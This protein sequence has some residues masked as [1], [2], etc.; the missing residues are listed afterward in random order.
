MNAL[1]FNIMQLAQSGQHNEVI[2][3]LAKASNDNPKIVDNVVSTG[4]EWLQK[5]WEDRK[6]PDNWAIV[7]TESGDEFFGKVTP[8]SW[9]GEPMLH[10][11]MPDIDIAE[12]APFSASPF[13]DDD[14][15][16]VKPSHV[17]PGV[18]LMVSMSSCEKVTFIPMEHC[19]QMQDIS[20]G[21]GDYT[22]ATPGYAPPDPIPFQSVDPVFEP[23]D[24]AE[25]PEAPEDA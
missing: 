19:L 12:S 13:E 14:G 5:R 18:Q 16:L 3:A 2:Q 21:L 15:L 7:Q 11:I 20:I 9:A 25:P 10:I 24:L 23:T 6:A 17:A 4:L 1:L 8:Q 22:M